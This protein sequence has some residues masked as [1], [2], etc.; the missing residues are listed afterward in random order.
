MG[1]VSKDDDFFNATIMTIN[2]KETSEEYWKFIQYLDGMRFLVV[3]TKVVQTRITHKSWN[4]LIIGNYFISKERMVFWDEPLKGWNLTS[5][6]WI[7][8]WVLRRP[9]SE[10]NHNRKDFTSKL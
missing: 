1:D 4:Y 2:V 3:A 6:V 7:S 9:L 5:F 8:C 10:T